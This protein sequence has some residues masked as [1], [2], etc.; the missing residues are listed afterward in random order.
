MSTPPLIVFGAGGH[1]KVVADVLARAGQAVMGFVDDGVPAGSSVLGLPVLGPTSWLR[2]HPAC[3][4]LGLGNN[5]ARARIAEYCDKA[6]LRLVTAIHPSAVIASSARVEAGAVVMAL[7]VVNADAVI[8]RGAILNTASVVEHDCHVGAFAHV[9]PRA[10]MAGGC[11]LGAS[12][13]LGVGASMLP[14]TSIGDD[15]I[16]GGGA[17]VA[18]AIPP[19]VIAIGVP[20]RVR[21]AAR[22]A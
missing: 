9:S 12:A 8:E 19:S 15:T 4:A 20:A 18:R 14:G 21:R 13:Q 5:V 10:V 22:E 7:V 16:V 6:G 11:R 17:L 3:V 2:D 1:G